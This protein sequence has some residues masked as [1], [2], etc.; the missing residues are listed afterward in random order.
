MRLDTHVHSCYSG[1]STIRGLKHLLHE[2]YNTPERIYGLAKQRGMD[3]V[4]IT[5]HDSISGALTIA[6]RPDVIVGCEVSAAFTHDGVQVH[7]GVLGLN[8]AQF[9]DIMRLRRDL[10]ELLPYL[11]EQQ[12]FVS[13]NHV[14]SRVRGVLT[15]EHVA[16]LMPWVDGLE[17]INGARLRSQN[18][19]AYRLALANGKAL[20]AG[21]DA[22]TI[23]G[24]GETWVEARGA[25][26]REEFL[27][28]LR[29][30]RVRPGGRHGHYFTMTEDILRT[31]AGMYRQ[32]AVNLMRE[33]TSWRRHAS[34]AAL[35]TAVPLLTLAFAIAA[36]H[37]GMEMQFNRALLFD[38]GRRPALNVAG[39]A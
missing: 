14:G 13:L 29:A 35:V 6:H 30:R 27:A 22:H 36:A 28:D 34:M 26:T 18:R 21:S 1:H 11:R 10:T 16:A 32:Q 33:P 19:T 17:V 24:I 15:A 39:L 31:Y 8:E 5:D 20:I 25:R 3:L 23:R 12:L 37:F 4:T 9:A 2:S 38:I 7:L